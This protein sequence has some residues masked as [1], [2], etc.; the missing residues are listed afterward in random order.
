MTEGLRSGIGQAWQRV[1][2]IAIAFSLLVVIPAQAGIQ[3]F[4]QAIPASGGNDN[5]AGAHQ[6]QPLF[7]NA[8]NLEGIDRD[9]Y[10]AFAS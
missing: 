7:G 5:H 4:R 3:W 1:V 2:G 6:R 10:L 8:R 9:L